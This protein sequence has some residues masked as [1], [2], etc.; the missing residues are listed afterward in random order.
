MLR[1]PRP[2]Y[3]RR[4]SARP[5]EVN[6]LRNRTQG[7]PSIPRGS[8]ENSPVSGD[9]SVTR[10]GANDLSGSVIR[11]LPDRMAPAFVLLSGKR[12]A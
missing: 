10:V 3:A 5:S 12:R 1:E 7:T 11:G 2:R 4:R 8:T 9:I 6:A